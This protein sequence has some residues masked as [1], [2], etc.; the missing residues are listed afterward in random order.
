MN[1][2]SEQPRQYHQAA[3][4]QEWTVRFDIDGFRFISKLSSFRMY[5]E[6]RESHIEEHFNLL[7]MIC[8]S[9]SATS[10]HS[11]NLIMAVVCFISIWRVFHQN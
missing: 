5:D 4:F 9:F 7:S 3:L 2:E 11:R 1:D 6:L 10:W 8:D